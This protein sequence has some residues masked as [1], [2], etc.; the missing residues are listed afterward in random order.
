MVA[1]KKSGRLTIRM[2]AVTHG[3]AAGTAASLGM[4]INDLLNLIIREGLVRY[5]M[6]AQMLR[7]PETLA[8]LEQWRLSNPT[9]ETREFFEDYFRAHGGIPTMFENGKRYI[10]D[11]GGFMETPLNEEIERDPRSPDA[12]QA[13]SDD[14]P[15]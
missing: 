13:G 6:E 7:Q 8:L 14:I 1:R 11:E 9:R 3:R 10:L 2:D 15:F 5:E 4:G 12:P